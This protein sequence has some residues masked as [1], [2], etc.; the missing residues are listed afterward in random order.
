MTS[1]WLPG[2]RL[3]ALAST[4][5]TARTRAAK[6][7]ATTGR[8]KSR[9]RTRS[10]AHQEDPTRP[11]AIEAYARICKQTINHRMYQTEGVD[12]VTTITELRTKTTE[13][14]DFVRESH[15][16]VMIQR[17]ND[18]EAVLISWA[19]Y[20]EIKERAGEDILTG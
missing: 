7:V 19:L 8:E 14:I 5:P 18:P 17:N 3:P 15:Q 1:R 6:R 10:A 12:A 2:A 4:Q 20:K 11:S 13:M 9:G 16:G